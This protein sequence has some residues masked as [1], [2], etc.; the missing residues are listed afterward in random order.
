LHALTVGGILVILFLFCI[1]CILLKIFFFFFLSL[2]LLRFRNKKHSL[3]VA[4]GF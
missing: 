4:D 1:Y 2:Q 3:F